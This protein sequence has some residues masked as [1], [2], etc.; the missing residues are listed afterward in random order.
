MEGRQLIEDELDRLA[1]EF[2][3]EQGKAVAEAQHLLYKA[4]AN[5]HYAAMLVK[6]SSTPD[7]RLPELAEL[8][9]QGG[10]ADLERAVA[11]VANQRKPGGTSPIF[12]DWV[13]KDP[14][15]KEAQ[16][17]L[18]GTPRMRQFEA[19]VRSARPPRAR[20]EDLTPTYSDHQKAAE[21]KAAKNAPRTEFFGGT[22]AVRRQAG[23]RVV[24]G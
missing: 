16:A 21:E 23:R 10:L 24:E 9:S 11:R 1:G 17:R 18:K 15:R 7:E 6:A 2:G 14:A 13:A 22:P 20:P 8:A 5:E 4:G 3:R 12:A 19:R